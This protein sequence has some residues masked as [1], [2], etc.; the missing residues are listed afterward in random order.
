MYLN[1]NKSRAKS[2]FI[3]KT[4]RIMKLTIVLLFATFL[5]VSAKDAYTQKVTLKENNVSLQKVFTQIRK[6]TNFNF[7]YADEVLKDA[8]KVSLNVKNSSMDEVLAKCFKDQNLSYTISEK[9]IVIKRKELETVPN[10]S[11]TTLEI[12]TFEIRGRVTDERGRP[13]SGVSVV[14]IKER[15]GNYY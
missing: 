7:F 6:Q 10:T 15:P 11:L 2:G 12:N 3:K 5:Q 13:I 8:K 9:T 14:I 4:I 1:V